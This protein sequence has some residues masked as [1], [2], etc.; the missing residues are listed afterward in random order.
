[1]YPKIEDLVLYVVYIVYRVVRIK[2]PTFI[3]YF[4]LSI[5]IM[6]IVP[7]NIHTPTT[8]GIPCK[9]PLLPGISIF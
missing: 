9:Y 2:N 5:E 7:E 6:C 1:L 4:G 8:E 3:Q